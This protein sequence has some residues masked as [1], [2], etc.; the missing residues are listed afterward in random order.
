MARTRMFTKMVD[1]INN[2][3]FDKKTFQDNPLFLTKAG[4]FDLYIFQEN[5]RMHI[6]TIKS[7]YHN[8]FYQFRR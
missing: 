3:Q 4:H 8:T 2:G 5:R 1:V 7:V 6:R